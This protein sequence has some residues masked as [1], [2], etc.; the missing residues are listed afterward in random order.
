MPSKWS[1]DLQTRAP[2][3]LTL[4]VLV[5][6]PQAHSKVPGEVIGSNLVLFIGSALQTVGRAAV[7][8]TFAKVGGPAAR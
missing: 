1:C 4:L 6:R 8:T 5:A 2:F 3:S 7:G